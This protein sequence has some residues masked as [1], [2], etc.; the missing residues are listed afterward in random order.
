MLSHAKAVQAF[1]QSD[2]KEGS[3]GIVL[4]FSDVHPASSS[5]EDEETAR[6]V[7]GFYNRWFLDPVLKGSY[8]EDVLNAYQCM[9]DSP[10]VNNDDMRIIKENAVDFLG[11]NY[12]TRTVVRKSDENA[13]LGY[14]T[15]T[16]ENASF[17]GIGWEIYPQGLYN[18]LM[19]IKRDYG[20]IPVYITENGA[21]FGDDA[22]VGGVVQDNDR[23][24]YIRHH[25]GAVNSAI[26]DGADVKGYFLWSLMDNFE[27]SHGYRQRFGV[28]HT[29]YETLERTW[30]ESAYWY[31]TVIERNGF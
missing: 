18:V 21:A 5:S 30:K 29:N 6:L 7:D 13:F 26:V 11:V 15:A 16:P 2:C 4:Y 28:I 1:R 8:P 25:L 27:W 12:Y 22:I 20:N 31:K 3:V 19:R 23:I 14:E 24:E 9:F 17:T 10:V